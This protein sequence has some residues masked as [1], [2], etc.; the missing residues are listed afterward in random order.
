[1]CSL[2]IMLLNGN[3]ALPFPCFC[4]QGVDA[5]VSYPEFWVPK[6]HGDHEATKQKEPGSL[7][8]QSCYMSYLCPYC[9]LGINK[10][11]SLRDPGVLD[12][13]QISQ[14]CILIQ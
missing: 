4:Y 9:Y 14:I 13:G 5:M 8:P 11:L 2:Q 12:L 1:M 3:C 10:I 7:T 6:H